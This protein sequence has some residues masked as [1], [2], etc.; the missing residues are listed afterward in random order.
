MSS[1]LP[2]ID[3]EIKEKEKL[4]SL[5]SLIK[6]EKIE[7]TNITSFKTTDFTILI[8]ELTNSKNEG[9]SLYK[10][11]KYD[12]AIKIYKQG[13]ETFNKDSTKVNI[14]IG[15]N[16]QSE[17]VLLLFKKNLANIALSYYKQ[18]KFEKSIEYDLK[19]I[20]YDSKY[21][22]SYIRLFKAYKKLNK[23]NQAVFFANIFLKFD[24]I[25]K[26]K[27]KNINEEIK[28]TK[29][30]LEK[31]Q[32]KEKKK[33]KFNI[34]KMIAPIIVLLISIIIFFFFKKSKK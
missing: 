5:N 20:R 30:K 14:E 12:D 2:I 33:I 26:N 29:N 6:T 34:I 23:L 21:D 17:E 22:R 13:V 1:N 7:Q 10:Q 16:K 8:K 11:K 24:E 18:G 4:P 25:T 32:N 19:I 28:D 15:Y 9:N 31:L 3:E 27:Y